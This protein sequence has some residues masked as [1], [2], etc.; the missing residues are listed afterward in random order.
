MPPRRARACGLA[1]CFTSFYREPKK[2]VCAPSRVLRGNRTVTG[3][4]L[5]GGT[6][7][8]FARCG[9]RNRDWVPLDYGSDQTAPFAVDYDRPVGV[10][11]DRYTV[12][13]W[14]SRNRRDAS[15]VRSHESVRSV[16][17][18]RKLGGYVP[19]VRQRMAKWPCR[20]PLELYF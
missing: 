4:D 10:T 8:T 5:R 6:P 15:S 19:P 20:G 7:K 18:R 16:A 1:G 2:T 12:H 14:S 17:M 11:R 9:R 3:L 13:P